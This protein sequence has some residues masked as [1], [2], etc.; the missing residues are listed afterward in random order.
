MMTVTEA[1]PGVSNVMRGVRILLLVS[2]IFWSMAGCS[3]AGTENA[4]LPYAVLG[5]TGTP[6]Q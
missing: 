5:S 6:E 4:V 1:L 2:L 3:E